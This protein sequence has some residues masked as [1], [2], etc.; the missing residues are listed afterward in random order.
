MTLGQSSPQL[1]GREWDIIGLPSRGRK[2]YA[3]KFHS[4]AMTCT[5]GCRILPG[6]T[7]K[8][9]REEV[10]VL[11][12][13]TVRPADNKTGGGGGRRIL[14]SNSADFVKDIRKRGADINGR[15]IS[16]LRGSLCLFQNAAGPSSTAP[17]NFQAL[18]VPTMSPETTESCPFFFHSFSACCIPPMNGTLSKATGRPRDC[19]KRY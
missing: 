4:L 11:G 17:K 8:V 13:A 9:L 16:F 6:N 19:L 5:R 10:G 15:Y 7:G 18:R 14:P 2:I 3:E 12:S 1:R